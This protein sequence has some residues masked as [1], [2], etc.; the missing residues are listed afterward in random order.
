[1]NR[2]VDLFVFDLAGTVVVDDDHVLRAFVATC[3]LHDLPVGADRLRGCMG[4][5]K[6][7]VFETLLAELGHGILA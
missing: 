3:E 2:T 5:H 1:M 7:K 6:E 4:W